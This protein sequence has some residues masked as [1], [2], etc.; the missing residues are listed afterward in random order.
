MSWV[1]LSGLFLLL[2]GSLLCL[3]GS[4]AF[5]LLLTQ[6]LLGAHVVLVAGIGAGVVG[7][8]GR[9]LVASIFL[10]PFVFVITRIGATIIPMILLNGFFPLLIQLVPPLLLP[11]LFLCSG[12]GFGWLSGLVGSQIV[13]VA[14][15]VLRIVS[16]R[17]RFSLLLLTFSLLSLLLLSL[18][19]FSFL[20]LAF[21]LLTLLLLA[22]LL[23]VIVSLGLRIW[24]IFSLL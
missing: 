11:F 15:I 21:L 9:L 23:L 6:L 5:L 17:L 2:F 3:P 19:L 4:V 8:I 7:G 22:L 13:F 12:I 14:G 24:R 20:L 1:L 18:L 16:V 10:G